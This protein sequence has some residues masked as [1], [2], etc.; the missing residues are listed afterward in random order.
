MKRLS[1]DR[2]ELELD[3]HLREVVHLGLHDA[4]RET[5]LRNPVHEDA[6]GLVEGL[7]DH[8]LV[9]EA[10]EVS[11][12]RQARRAR[13]DDRHAPAGRRADVRQLDAALLA[14]PVGEKRLD[15]ADGDGEAEVL[16]HLGHHAVLLA[17]AL[18]R[19][20]APADRRQEV[21]LLDEP[22]R[23]AEVALGDELQEPRHVDADRASRDAR[24]VLA[25]ETA[26]GFGARL[27][28][29]VGE[30]DLA[31]VA[32]PLGRVLL[33]PEDF[34]QLAPLPGRQGVAGLDSLLEFLG[35]RV[36]PDFIGHQASASEAAAGASNRHVCIRSR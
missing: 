7:E 6:A 9:A 17:L 14:F 34:R 2:V 35:G 27:R 15:L 30:R 12:A 10:P 33:G 28:G 18:L 23:A 25:R 36:A 19:A 13:A 1:D 22:D 5:E 32:D 8:R 21:G 31:D 24:L 3:A 29:R 26:H 4:L 16:V 11:R 20:D